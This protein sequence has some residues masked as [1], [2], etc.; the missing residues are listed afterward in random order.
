MV[1]RS[2]RVRG[3]STCPQSPVDGGQVRD[4]SSGTSRQ[5]GR[6]AV[7][8]ISGGR[9]R[10]GDHPRGRSRCACSVSTSRSLNSSSW[11]SSLGDPDEMTQL[12]RN[13][14]DASEGFSASFS[15]SFWI[16][17]LLYAVRTAGTSPSSPR[18][19][20]TTSR[21]TG[22]QV[23]STETGTP[24]DTDGVRRR[25][26]VPAVSVGEDLAV[27]TGRA[28]GRPRPAT[29]CRTSVFSTPCSDSRDARVKLRVRPLA[30]RP[31][32]SA[33]APIRAATNDGGADSCTS[34]SFQRTFAGRPE[35]RWRDDRHRQRLRGTLVRESR[36]LDHGPQHVRAARGPAD[37]GG[38][39]VGRQSTAL[40]RSSSSRTIRAAAGDEGG[41]VFHFVTVG[42]EAALDQAGGRPW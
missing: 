27:V 10:N 33:L 25:P 5:S 29:S 42:I 31:T 35:A 18:G 2:A 40:R 21:R 9:R 16:W 17:I 3:R 22:V 26:G 11:L 4:R 28:N 8:G 7:L 13:P 20:T 15:M 32:A 36:R 1:F 14:T 34:G 23:L 30:C 38:R 37:H 19:V 41:T 12:A 6:R 24:P 39:P